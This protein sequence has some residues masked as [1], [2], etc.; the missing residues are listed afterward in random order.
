MNISDLKSIN[1]RPNDKMK[2]LVKMFSKKFIILLNNRF[3][4]ILINAT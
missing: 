4:V 1:K 3:R 2:D